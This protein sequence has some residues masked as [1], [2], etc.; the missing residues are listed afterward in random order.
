MEKPLSL[1]RLNLTPMKIEKRNV[2]D[3][4]PEKE[5][6]DVCPTSLRASF[7]YSRYKWNI[8]QRE[9]LL[10]FFTD[11]ILLLFFPRDYVLVGNMV[12]MLL[13]PFLLIS[14]QVIAFYETDKF[15]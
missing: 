14:V 10:L 7:S 1:E 4:L 9:I 8:E 13:L 3:L 6:T 5:F 12:V 2:D 11:I 15:L